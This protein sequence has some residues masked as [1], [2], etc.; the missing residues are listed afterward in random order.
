MRLGLIG[1][2][3]IG[4][5][6]A[7]ILRD[8]PDVV[9]VVVAARER[10]RE[11]IRDLL[12]AVTVV[13]AADR[14]IEARPDVVVECA[15][16]E[17][18]RAYAEPVLAAGIQLVALS[19]GVLADREYRER[20]VNAAYMGGGVLEIPAGAIGGIDV[21]SAARHAGLTRVTYTTRKNPETWRGTPAETMVDLDDVRTP[22]LFFD[23]N[24]ER[25]ALLFKSKANVTATIALA[26]VGFEATRVQFWADPAI[27][28]S[29]HHVAA[30]SRCGT[31]EI[32]LANEVASDGKSSLLAAMSVVRA[33]RNRMAVFRL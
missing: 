20:V 3:G 33:I 29:T 27:T 1:F 21:L 9:F 2:G 16:H 31:V 26:G 13:T 12:G 8:D 7:S 6:V 23:S 28:R 25:A 11:E 30:E 32:E 14:L 4:R 24:A 22:C 19:I 10:Q 17:A 15:G 5:I 18:F